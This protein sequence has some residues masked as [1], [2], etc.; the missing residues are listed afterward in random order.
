MSGNSFGTLFRLTTFGES[1]GVAIG[2]VIEGCPAGMNFDISAIQRDLDRRRPGQSALTTPRNESDTIEILSGVF[3]GKTLGT[4]IGFIIRNK[5]HQSTDYD[6]LKDV[7]RPGHADQFWQ[8]K[9]GIRDHRGG[10]RSSARET[11]ARVVGGAVAKQLLSAH[12]IEIQAYVSSVKDIA[13]KKKYNELDLSQ[14]ETSMVRCPDEE[15]AQLMIALIERARSEGDS[16]GGTITC[17]ARHVP[18]G[19]GAPVF[20][21]LQARLA[22]GVLSINATKGFEMEDGFESTHR[23][24][25]ENNPLPTGITGGLSTGNDIVFRVAF[26]PVSTISKA[27]NTINS[28]GEEVVLQAKGRHDPCVLPRAVSIVEAMTALVL[29]DAML[30]ARA[31]RLHG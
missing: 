13:L 12:G 21:K 26:K 11:A 4:P 29:A 6:V 20:D 18:V 22:Q 23:F 15:T 2:G 19:W 10:G 8:E 27:Q 9:Y 17:V 16:V 3:E 28:A 7:F 31:D 30:L 24:G 25:S 1:H 14:T 5:D